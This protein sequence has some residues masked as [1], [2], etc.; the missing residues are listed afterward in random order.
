MPTC[1]RLLA[2]LAVAAGGCSDRPKAPPLTNEAVYQNDKVGV[3]FLTP[4]GW[5]AMSRSDL[6][7]GE[8][9][10]PVVLVA[11]L[12]PRG[13]RPAQFELVAADVPDGTD[14]GKYLAE[15][16]IGPEKWVVKA[17]PEPTTVGGLAGSRYALGR[18]A[19]KDSIR[20]EVAAV[21]RGGRVYFFV[22]TFGT[23]DVEHRDQ[24]RKSVESVT[25]SK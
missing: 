23:S 18:A 1:P 4:D 9:S 20:Q 10:R 5:T 14:L 6:P 21:R 12:L 15:H 16:P 3:R 13:D 17:G 2:L 22:A 25:W 19:G 7:P 24:A 11:Y 8:L